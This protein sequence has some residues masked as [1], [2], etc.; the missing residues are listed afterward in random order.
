MMG[1]DSSVKGLTMNG[2]TAAVG[3]ITSPTI[4]TGCGKLKFKYGY[5]F[6]ESNGIKFKVEIKQDGAVVK[7]YTIEDKT[8]T[9]LA[10]YD[11]EVE[12]NISGEFQIV[13]TNL[14]PSNK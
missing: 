12:V 5:P 4:T 8:A 13:F 3:T 9:K 11:Y 10:A 1:T 14:C 2:K 7:T 6:S